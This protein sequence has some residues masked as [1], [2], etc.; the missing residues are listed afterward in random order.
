MRS[1]NRKHRQRT[2]SYS[3]G[4]V[5]IFLL[6][7][8]NVSQGM[9]LCLGAYGHVAIEP[10]GHRHCGGATHHHDA[11][12]GSAHEEAME[13]VAQGRCDPCVDIALP[14]APLDGKALS[15]APRI[16][17]TVAMAEP[18]S[19]CRNPLVPGVAS[20]AILPARD[21]PLRTIVLQ[22]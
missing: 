1:M 5:L 15:A 13:F 18:P 12:D 10:A 14:L 6:V 22:V 16:T 20:S 21:A 9:V 8:I 17:A 7:A 4:V 2:S 19:V 3:L 11:D